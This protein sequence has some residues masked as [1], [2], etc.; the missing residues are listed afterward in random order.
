M[1]HAPPDLCRLDYSLRRHF[2]DKFYFRHVPKLP[3]GSLVLDLGGTKVRKRGRFDI[4]AF[5]VKVEY[6]NIDPGTKPD[7]VCDAVSVPVE[8][9]TFDAVICAELLEHVLRPVDVLCEACRLLK[10]GGVLLLTA[11]F[12]VNIHGHPDDYGRYTDTW[13]AEN[14]SGIG[15]E[16]ATVERQGMI[17]SVL[18]DMLKRFAAQDIW[19]RGRLGR[20]LFRAAVVRWTRAALRL[21]A[22]GRFADNRIVAGYTTGLGVRAVKAGGA[23]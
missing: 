21:E 20:R 12:H 14:L 7:Y 10:P 22:A 16:V 17:F 1:S 6:A 19:P 11:P 13:L 8:D 9:G 5:P 18:A 15:F 3:A 4:S 2:V 23:P